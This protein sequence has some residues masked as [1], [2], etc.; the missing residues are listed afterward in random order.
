[1]T[2]LVDAFVNS[3]AILTR[4]GKRVVFVSNRDGLPQLYIADVAS[5]DPR[6]APGARG[7]SA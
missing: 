5:P 1:M 2:P 6:E 4:D 7:P 3:E